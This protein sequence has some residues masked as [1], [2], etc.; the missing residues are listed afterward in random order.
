MLERAFKL[1]DVIK[2]YQVAYFV[3]KDKP[4]TN[5]ILNSVD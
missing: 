1:K 4:I 3:D 2:L 5:D